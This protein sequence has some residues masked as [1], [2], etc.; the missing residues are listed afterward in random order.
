MIPR[1]RK[2]KV[3]FYKSDLTVV[4]TTVFCVKRFA[5]SF[6]NELLGYPRIDSFDVKVGLVR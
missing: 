6:A 2:W 3:T 4:S 1:P 5:I